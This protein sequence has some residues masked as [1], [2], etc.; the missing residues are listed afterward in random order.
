MEEVLLAANYQFVD[1]MEISQ[2]PI[3]GEFQYLFMA[4]LMYDLQ[5]QAS[6]DLCLLQ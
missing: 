5:F 6:S 1:L 3:P 2:L 4:W